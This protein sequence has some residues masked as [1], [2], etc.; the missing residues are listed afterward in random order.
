MST[1]LICRLFVLIV[2]FTFV[3]SE[4]LVSQTKID[5]FESFLNV[6]KSPKNSETECERRYR[7]KVQS[8]P[9]GDLEAVLSKRSCSLLCEYVRCIYKYGKIPGWYNFSFNYI[10]K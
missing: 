9:K 6:S 1:E 8:C 7:E 2:A 5:L 10:S 4:N 3:N